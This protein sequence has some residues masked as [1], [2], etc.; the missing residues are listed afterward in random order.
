MQID[1]P[2]L[3]K[4]AVGATPPR[5]R[6]SP[7][8]PLT[9]RNIIDFCNDSSGTNRL[10]VGAKSEQNALSCIRFVTKFVCSLFALRS[11]RVA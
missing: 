6:I 5:V 2:M 10:S 3:L 4:T 9:Y 11:W 7:L 1:T 8:P